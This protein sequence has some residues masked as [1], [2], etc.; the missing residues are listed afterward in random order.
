MKDLHFP[1]FF[2]FVFLGGT[3]AITSTEPNLTGRQTFHSAMKE[4]LRLAL[5]QACGDE[6]NRALPSDA[7]VGMVW[8]ILGFLVI[9]NGSLK[10]LSVLAFFNDT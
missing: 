1:L 3:Q 7:Q 6:R 10:K 9:L 4:L 2:F 8:L 5:S